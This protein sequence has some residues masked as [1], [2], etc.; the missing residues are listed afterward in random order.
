MSAVYKLESNKLLANF[1]ELGL[2]M[3]W[4]EVRNLYV[5]LETKNK[6]KL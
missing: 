3:T 6:Q 2:T 1:G 5:P 4:L